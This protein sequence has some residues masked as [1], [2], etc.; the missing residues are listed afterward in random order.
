MNEDR[1]SLL[2]PTTV[3]FKDIIVT[4]P[5]SQMANAAQEA[6]EC[7]AANGGY[8]FRRLP[9]YPF[10]LKPKGGRVFYVE[11][12]YIRGYAVTCDLFRNEHESWTCETTGITYPPGVFVVMTAT[13]WTWIDPIPMKGFQGWRY[14]HIPKSKIHVV[15]YWRD[16]KPE[17]KTQ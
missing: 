17:V 5:K 6:E 11:D 3:Q 1:Y 12:G 14:L 7:K 2:S 15:G 16:P 8:Y 13:S 9:T 10:K 4:T